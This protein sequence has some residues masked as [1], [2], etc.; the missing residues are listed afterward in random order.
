[1]IYCMNIL[2]I[3]REKDHDGGAIPLPND[4]YEVWQGKDPSLLNDH[5][6]Q[7]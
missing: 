5:E 2:R 6:C 7:A 1:M 3:D 4:R